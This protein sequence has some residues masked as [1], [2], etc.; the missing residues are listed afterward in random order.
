MK[1]KPAHE[2]TYFKINDLVIVQVAHT[3]SVVEIIK[4]KDKN[5]AACCNN[6]HFQIS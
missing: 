3:L 6:V 5:L 4:K 1:K 2:N